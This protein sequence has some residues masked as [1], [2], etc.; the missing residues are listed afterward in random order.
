MK[1]WVGCKLSD[2][3]RLR[4]FWNSIGEIFRPKGR[5]KQEAWEDDKVSCPVIFTFIEPWSSIWHETFCNRR[6]T[7]A[8]CSLLVTKT[9]LLRLDGA[10]GVVVGKALRYISAGRG[11]DSRWCHW[12]FQWHKPSSRTMALG[13]N[14]PLTE[15]STRCI[16]WGK[17]GRCVRLTTLPPFC[18]VMKS[19]KL[20]FLEL[21][22]SLQ[23]CNGTALPLLCLDTSLGVAVRQ[24]FKC[25]VRIG[26]SLVCIICYSR[27][28]YTRKSE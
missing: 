7:Q 2:W 9:W 26:R 13:S 27:V 17:G 8:S 6:L 24:M 4:E 1:S 19:G 21:S 12:N 3:Y 10:R 15:I 16:S 25:Q 23:A 11:F 18:V 5:K 20:N 22:G 14:Q 28:K